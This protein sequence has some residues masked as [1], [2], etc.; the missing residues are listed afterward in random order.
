MLLQGRRLWLA[1]VVVVAA[2]SLVVYVPAGR[3]AVLEA[4]GGAATQLA[5]GFHLRVP[6]YQHL[7][8][9]DSLPVTIDDKIDVVSRDH[10]AFKLPARI[11]GHASPSD[12]L[13]FHKERA[14]RE[15]RVYIE[16]RMRE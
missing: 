2:A 10:A 7:Y 15:P 3:A 6:L 12:V 1:L 11:S 14:G 9:Y 5:P 13:T 8:V 4:R 16:E